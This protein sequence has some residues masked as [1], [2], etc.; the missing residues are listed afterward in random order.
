MQERVIN[1]TTTKDVYNIMIDGIASAFGV[2]IKITNKEVLARQT[3]IAF[4]RLLNKPDELNKVVDGII[5]DILDS[6]IE[7]E[8]KANENQ[9]AITLKDTLRKHLSNLGI[10]V[11]EFFNDSVS[12]LK[13]ILLDKSNDSK[14]KKLRN[15]FQSKIAVLVKLVKQYRNNSYYIVKSF[16]VH[17]KINERLKKNKLPR[18]VGDRHIAELEFYYQAT[19]NI[20]LSRSAKGD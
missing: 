4:N 3:T 20:K 19:K 7:Y 14:V 17:K 2:D 5:N 10:N 6:K 16:Q 9:V 8:V 13:D 11:N 18:Q 12:I 15:Y 1:M